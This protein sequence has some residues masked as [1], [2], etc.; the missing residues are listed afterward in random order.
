MKNLILTI[1]ILIATAT[2]N[3]YGQ[4]ITVDVVDTKL[5]MF[6]KGEDYIDFLY[7]NAIMGGIDTKKECTYVFDI[8]NSLE[9]KKHMYLVQIFV[10][11]E[12]IV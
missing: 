6:N 8:E 4:V 5:L 10:S 12:Y 11:A 9:L 7:T 1:G 2:T 3:I